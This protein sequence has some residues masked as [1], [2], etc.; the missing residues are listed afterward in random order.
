MQIDIDLN[1][2]RNPREVNDHIRTLMDFDGWEEDRLNE[3]I[4][5]VAAV[6]SGLVPHLR[7]DGPERFTFRLT[8][9]ATARNSVLRAFINIMR[10]INR[11]SVARTGHS[12]IALSIE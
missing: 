12:V 10:R 6:N 3:W 9:A 5:L 7:T 1:D 2:F 8:N 4:E 11:Q